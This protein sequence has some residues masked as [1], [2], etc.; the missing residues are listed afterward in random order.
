VHQRD[1]DE[2]EGGR[3]GRERAE[4]LGRHED[5]RHDRRGE[6]EPLREEDRG[7]GQD[8]PSRDASAQPQEALA[9]HPQ[10]AE[11]REEDRRPLDHPRNADA[12]EAVLRAD[13]PERRVLD[14]GRLGAVQRQDPRDEGQHEGDVDDAL[15][16]RVDLDPLP[17]QQHQRHAVVLPGEVPG[18]DR[19]VEGDDDRAHERIDEGGRA[20]QRDGERHPHGEEGV[21]AA[22]LGALVDTQKRRPDVGVAPDQEQQRHQ[23][24][25]HGRPR[26]R[27]GPEQHHQDRDVEE[28]AAQDDVRDGTLQPPTAR[29]RTHRCHARPGFARPGRSVDRVYTPPARGRADPIG[30]RGG[31]CDDPRS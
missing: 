6:P 22:V 27:P 14:G 26:L 7:A 9:E 18:H 24:E 13:R 8:L 29:T 20:D 19:Q 4:V 17:A 1:P 11:D 16:A 10:V 2:G 28:P 15:R 21:G 30:A 31:F 12:D 23:Q 5:L 3:A 25:G